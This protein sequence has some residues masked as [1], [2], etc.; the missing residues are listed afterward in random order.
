MSHEETRLKIRTFL[1]ENFAASGPLDQLGDDE[2]LHDS[3]IIDSFGILSLI[4]FLEDEFGIH[5]SDDEVVPENLDAISR[6]S[7]FIAKKTASE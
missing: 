5:V 4:T 3:G 6:L 1:A 2:S 7:A